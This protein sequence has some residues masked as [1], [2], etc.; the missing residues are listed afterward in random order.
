MTYPF[1]QEGGQVERLGGVAVTERE[2]VEQSKQDDHAS[3][4]H[5][6]PR[7][8]AVAWPGTHTVSVFFHFQFP[9]EQS[10]PSAFRFSSL[11]GRTDA[12]AVRASEV[13]ASRASRASMMVVVVVVGGS[14]AAE[15][16]HSLQVVLPPTLPV[17]SAWVTRSGYRRKKRQSGGLRYRRGS[18]EADAGARRRCRWSRV[19]IRR[20]SR[21]KPAGGEAG[22]GSGLRVD[23]GASWQM[24]MLQV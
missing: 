7:E 8:I 18:E 2:P 20:A 16:N 14:G 22:F 11:G 15:A 23:V 4:H 12:C 5:S 6:P 10:D 13:R 3:D 19:S 24:A 1:G 17:G 9:V 21:V